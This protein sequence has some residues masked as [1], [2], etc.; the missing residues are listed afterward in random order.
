VLYAPAFWHSGRPLF[1]R[2]C[3]PATAGRA[4]AG[5]LTRAKIPSEKAAG[6]GLGIAGLYL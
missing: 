1:K 2:F 6:E 3:R 4:G 5:P